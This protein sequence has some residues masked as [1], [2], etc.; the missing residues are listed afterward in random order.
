MASNTMSKTEQARR[1]VQTLRRAVSMRVAS[2]FRAALEKPEHGISRQSWIEVSGW[3]LSTPDEMVTGHV[4]ILPGRCATAE[5]AIEFP[6]EFSGDRPD[7]IAFFQLKNRNHALG[8]STRIPW[9]EIPAEVNVVQLCVSLSNGIEFIGLGPVTVYRER[10]E[11][12]VPRGD[13]KQVW[14]SASD[15][16]SAAMIAV[17]GFSDFNSFMESGE[18]TAGTLADHLQ[19][20]P[21]DTVLEIGCGVGR[22]GIG[23]AKR[24][25]KWIGTDISGQML[26]YARENLKRASCANFSLHE[27]SDCS[28]NGIQDASVDKLYCSAV[29]MH[30]DEWDR[31]RYVK[32]TFRVLKP[33]GRAYFD[34]LDIESDEGW[35]I[36]EEL[37]RLDPAERPPNISKCSTAQELS[38]YL[39]RAGFKNVKT[40]RSGRFVEAVGEK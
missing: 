30:L 31:Y 7:V 9:S 13:Y 4:T 25:Q 21:T 1:A 28:L 27:L 22:V 26:S 23:M 12:D 37:L 35:A 3:A 2:Q 5:D 38:T 33:G 10:S 14:D 15:S 36:F 11:K 17:A 29:F 24:C 6:L 8:F 32:E 34:N 20:S 18:I 16:N 40:G 19:V 39:K